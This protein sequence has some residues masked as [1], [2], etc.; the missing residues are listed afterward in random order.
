MKTAIA[1]L[2]GIG[3]VKS[4]ATVSWARERSGREL[5]QFVSERHDRLN[6]IDLALDEL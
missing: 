2:F 4:E 6:T 1:N 5:R 3:S